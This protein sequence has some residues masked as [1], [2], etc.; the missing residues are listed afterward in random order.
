MQPQCQHGQDCIRCRLRD[1]SETWDLTSEPTEEENLLL[2]DFR[3]NYLEAVLKFINESKD[4]YIHFYIPEDSCV[5]YYYADQPLQIFF[6][7]VYASTEGINDIVEKTRRRERIRKQISKILGNILSP[8]DYKMSSWPE[9]TKLANK[10]K[11]NY[12]YGSK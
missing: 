11:D 8:A 5:I 10:P 3:N 2:E 7:K 12:P 4:Y 9:I 6:K 1:A